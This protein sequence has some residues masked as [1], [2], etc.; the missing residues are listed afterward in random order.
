MRLTP[1]CLLY[2]VADLSPFSSVFCLLRLPWSKTNKTTDKRIRFDKRKPTAPFGQTLACPSWQASRQC[3][4]C[5]DSAYDLSLSLICHNYGGWLRCIIC[6]VY[7]FW[8]LRQALPA[9][10]I[11][12][13]LQ[14]WCG[15]YKRDKRWTCDKWTCYKITPL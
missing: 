2:L 14:Q 6:G 8:H 13:G 10:S 9:Y 1:L 3:A 15:I 4:E 12:N 7:A 5:Y 11:D